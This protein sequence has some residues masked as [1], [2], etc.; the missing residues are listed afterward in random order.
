MIKCC[1]DSTV[2]GSESIRGAE[3]MV[4]LKLYS[5]PEKIFGFFQYGFATLLRNG[6]LSRCNK[7]VD[8]FYTARESE[9]IV[10]KITIFTYRYQ[11]NMFG[12]L[13]ANY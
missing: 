10:E 6:S 8:F 3:P 11:N 4:L 12:L 5:D 9:I 7:Y 2:A 1:E 13:F